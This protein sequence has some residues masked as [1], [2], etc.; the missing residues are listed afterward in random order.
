MDTL[1]DIIRATYLARMVRALADA[2]G[3]AMLGDFERGTLAGTYLDAA[4]R[5]TAVA[6]A[7]GLGYVNY[8]TV[9]AV[10]DR[11]VRWF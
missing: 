8:L 3:A 1:A 7:W 10:A 9:A 11:N 5:L 6:D 4:D 2:H